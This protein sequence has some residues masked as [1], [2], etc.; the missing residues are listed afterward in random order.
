[1]SEHPLQLYAKRA[2]VVPRSIK[3]RF[4]LFKSAVMWVAFAIYFLL[5]WLP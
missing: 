3:G 2:A 4:R 1:M 5:P